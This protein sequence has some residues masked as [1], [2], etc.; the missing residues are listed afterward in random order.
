MHASKS[1]LKPAAA[2]AD[3]T[4]RSSSGAGCTCFK[5]RSLARRLTGVYDT[6][7]APYGITVTQYAALSVLARA[8]AP[9]AVSELAR[10]LQMDRTTTS[11]L[12]GPL[13]NERLV[14]RAVAHGKDADPRARPLEITAKG[15]R[16]LLVAR[17]AWRVAQR[18]VERA[19]GATL[20]SRLHRVADAASRALSDPAGEAS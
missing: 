15:R 8:S 9:L 3:G 18:Q 20:Q 11:R 19:L 14:D 13:A 12:I 17:P 10:R 1:A 5:V 6:A 2:V 4:A 16:R 7:L